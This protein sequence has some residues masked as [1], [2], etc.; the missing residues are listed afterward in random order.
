MDELFWLRQVAHLTAVASGIVIYLGCC[1]YVMGARSPGSPVAYSSRLMKSAASGTGPGL[2]CIAFG[3]AI[4]VCSLVFGAV[5]SKVSSGETAMS[6]VQSATNAELRGAP[7]YAHDPSV[8]TPSAAMPSA[9]PASSAVREERRP[10]WEGSA[11]RR[12]ARDLSATT[13]SID[14]QN[15][16][17]I[18][19]ASR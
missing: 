3:S 6:D 9:P 11:A 7:G 19:P 17:R 15:M 16:I 1:L 18:P 4:L 5:A 12:A 14:E 8:T 13:G 10:R 2:L